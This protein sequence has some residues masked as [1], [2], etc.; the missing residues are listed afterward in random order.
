MRVEMVLTAWCHGGGGSDDDK[1][2]YIYIYRW[3]LSV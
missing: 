1:G 3:W 2:I